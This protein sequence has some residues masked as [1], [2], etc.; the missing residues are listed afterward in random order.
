MLWEFFTSVGIM[1][2]RRVRPNITVLFALVSFYFI[3][4]TAAAF[5]NRDSLSPVAQSRLADSTAITLANQVSIDRLMADVEWLADDARQGRRT[6]APAED[7]V[8]KW[9]VE[10][11]HNMGLVNF[12]DAGLND[13][14]LPFP[15]PPGRGEN[16]LAVLPGTARPNSY[17]FIAAHYDHLGV[18]P[19][20]EVY[21]GADDNAAGVAAVL[22][23]ARILI[24][25]NLRP[26]ETIVFVAFS[27]EEVG[28]LGSRALCRRLKTRKLTSHSILLNMEVLGAIAGKG[29]FLDVW[30]EGV[31][32]TLPLVEAVQ[33]AGR[34][35]GIPVQ[36]QG[37]D[38]GSDALTMLFAGV[39]AV[40]VD[41]A[42]SYENHPHFHQ[43]SDDPEH[44]DRNGFHKAVQVMVAALWLLANDGR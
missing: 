18:S 30:D 10:R 28:T 12:A 14:Y 4:L 16:I 43:P 2:L 19:N 21:N 1:R 22:E 8:G 7:E 15:A 40:S 39:P 35:V 27:G 29:N 38:P 23:A 20:G 34:E 36:R 26:Q 33:L 41:V 6:G 42:W 37:C 13:Y 25:S 32:S 24:A 11:F 17:V 5:S 9:L 3:N 31:S 44:I